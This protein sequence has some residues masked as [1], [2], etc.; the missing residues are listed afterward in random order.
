MNKTTMGVIAVIIAVVSFYGGMSYGERKSATLAN[1]NTAF[2]GGQVRTGGVSGPTGQRGARVT[3]GNVS[4]SIV[5]KDA[6]SITVALRDGGSKIIFLSVNTTIS[7]IDAGG[8]G[9]LAAGKE[10]TVN[11]TPN[12]DGSITAQSIQLRPNF[13]TSTAR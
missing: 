6:T 8:L 2:Q 11:G 9:D 10:V 4:G 12:A 1:A 5:A 3:N 7:K 13:A